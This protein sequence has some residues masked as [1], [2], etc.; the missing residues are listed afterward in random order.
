[1][2]K[3]NDETAPA[4]D[5]GAIQIL[6]DITSVQTRP[7]MYIGDIHSPAATHHLVWEIVDNAVDEIL[8]GFATRV[9]VRLDPDNTVTVE[10]DGRGVPVDIHEKTGRPAVEAIFSTLHAGGKFGGSAYKTGSSGLHGVGSTAVNALSEFFEVDIR[11]DGGS[12]NLRFE[13]GRLVRPLTQTGKIARGAATGTTVRFRPSG[14]FLSFPLVDAD[15]LR[16]RLRR[17]AWLNRGVAIT[18]ETATPGINATADAS[19]DATADAKTDG[20]TKP[21][22]VSSATAASAINGLPAGMHSET[23]LSNEGLGDL[24][25]HETGALTPLCPVFRVEGALPI[26]GSGDV[27]VEAALLWVDED[28]SEDIH[29]FANTVPQKDGGAH[30]DGLRAAVV[31]ALTSFAEEQGLFKRGVKPKPSDLVEGMIAAV[32]VRMHDTAFSSQTKEK[33]ITPAARTAVEQTVGDRLLTW[34]ESDPETAKRLVA[35]ATLA[36][37]AREAARIAREQRRLKSGSKRVTSVSL[38][39]KLADCATRDRMRRELFIVEGDSAGGSAKQARDREFQAILPLRGKILNA[40]RAKVQALMKNTEVVGLTQTIGGGLGAG[41]DIDA[42]RY[43]RI[44][45]MTDADVDGAH[46]ATLLLT[47]FWRHMKP[48]IEEGRLYMAAPPLYRLRRGKN[49][50]YLTD[51]A[52][53]DRRKIADGMAALKEQP[54][55]GLVAPRRGKPMEQAIGLAV[56]V[57]AARETIIAALG[58]KDIANAVLSAPDAARLLS[59]ALGATAE[60]RALRAVADRLDRGGVAGETPAIGWSIE[61]APAAGTQADA[62]AGWIARF[63]IDGVQEEITIDPSQISERMIDDAVS[64][65]DILRAKNADDAG[66]LQAQAPDLAAGHASGDRQGPIDVV[67]RLIAAGERG[68]LI[69]RYKG[70]GEMNPEE[71]WETTMDPVKRRL[72]RIGVADAVAADAAFSEIMAESGAGRRNFVESLRRGDAE[73][74]AEESDETEESA[75]VGQGPDENPDATTAATTAANGAASARRTKTAPH[76]AAAT[77]AQTEKPSR[78]R[79]RRPLNG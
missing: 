77:A 46:I 48:L 20:K 9:R 79:S 43:G 54:E 69:S 40:E 23:Y 36:A 42:A 14:E 7:G 15:T 63:A 49:D 1:M 37:E 17:A 19:A 59:G 70:L 30:A 3:E 16:E 75:G 71:L 21:T 25:R 58:R 6:D 60:K 64:L 55:G 74:D 68:A 28:R 39:E 41:F 73:A 34:L 4:Y 78:T 32:H 52:E 10:D 47:L 66:A 5:A 29:A 35:R 24:V 62:N 67:D 12:Y 31:R 57:N 33:L 45:V 56:R 26:G 13:N 8:A 44:V 53:L 27:R 51:A 18:L 38:P 61:K 72:I 2:A 65:L 11:R 22:A 50:V 76:A